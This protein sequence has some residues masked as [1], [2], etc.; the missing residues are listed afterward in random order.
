LF[1]R[2]LVAFDGSEHS[3][4]A[5]DIAIRMAE[6]FCKK[7]TLIHVY[8]VAVRPIIIPEPATMTPPN[9]SILT[10]AEISEA[11]EAARREGKQMLEVAEQRAKAAGLEVEKILVEGQAA[12]EIVKAAKEGNFELIVMGARGLSLI[13]EL[14]LGS[15][16]EGV[17]RHA[18][19]PVLV[20]K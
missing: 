19:C 3:L 10:S 9:V 20:V 11:S 17:I 15:V 1:D 13:K 6:Q 8:S 5:L 7:L 18:P 16:S 4:R 14:L 12:Q 2:I